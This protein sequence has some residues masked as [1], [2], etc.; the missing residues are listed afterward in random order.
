MAIA[1]AILSGRRLVVLDEPTSGLDLYHMIQVSQMI[2][3]MHSLG[4]MVI[5]ISHDQEFLNQTCQRFI[6]F[7]E[8]KPVRDSKVLGDLLKALE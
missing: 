2:S 7:R 8:G 4:V 6:T 5:I 1:A 3:Y